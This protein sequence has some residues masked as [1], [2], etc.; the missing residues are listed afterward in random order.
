VVLGEDRD[1]VNHG[2]YLYAIKKPVVKD[3]QDA[4]EG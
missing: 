2:R 4:R 3:M 1:G